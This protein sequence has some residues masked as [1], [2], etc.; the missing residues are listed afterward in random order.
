M[1]TAIWKNIQ[2]VEYFSAIKIFRMYVWVVD[3]EWVTEV[4]TP[5]FSLT[6]WIKMILLA[7]LGILPHPTPFGRKIYKGS[8][9]PLKFSG[10]AP[11]NVAFI[12]QWCIIFYV[13]RCIFVMFI[14]L[15]IWLKMEINL[16]VLYVPRCIFVMFIYFSGRDY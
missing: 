14:P 16:R 10:S 9:P 13:P 15:Y 6:F 11:A 8:H 3:L 4:A 12:S 5:Y 2:L 1:E 7:I